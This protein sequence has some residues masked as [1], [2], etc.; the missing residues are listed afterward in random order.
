MIPVTHRRGQMLYV[1]GLGKTGLSAIAALAKGGAS[2]SGWDDGRTSRDAARLAGVTLTPPG[3][4]NWRQVD[5]LVL[6]PGVA[7]THPE[8]HEV[9]RLARA[10]DV[11]VIGDTELFVAEVRAT[12]KD[13]KI[14]AITGTNGKS[15]TTALVGHILQTAGRKVQIGGN[16]GSHAVLEL[17][18]YVNQTC[19]VIEFSSY[20]IDLTPSLKPDVAV[21][22]NLSPDHLDRHGGFS[23]Y[24]AVKA[25]IF[26]NQ[27]RGDNLVLGTDDAATAAMADRLPE[28][29]RVVPIAQDHAVPG[30]VYC[31]GSRLYDATSGTPE[32]VIDLEGFGALRGRHNR[33]NAAA[34]TAAALA[35][36][37]GRHDIASGLAGFGG[38]AHR[39]E[40]I[41]AAGR[42]LLVNDSKATNAASAER[43]LGS[44]RD[45]YW[46]AGGRAKAGGIEPLRP[47]FGRIAG[48][49]LIGEA[50]EEFAAT[51]GGAVPHQTCGT[52]EAAFARAAADAMASPAAEPV[53]LLAPACASFDQYAGFE[54]RGDEFRRLAQAL[55]KSET[56]RKGAS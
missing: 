53:V 29:V 10:H 23:G 39:M 35:L 1:F 3:E 13:A 33:Q 45:I 2:I 7:L 44:F 48:A 51:L 22:L 30:G 18:R 49:Y 56:N 12:M 26:A 31:L 34:A 46:I 15:T 17:K 41:G 40:E 4:V 28:G 24:A 50:A 47:L 5:A 32:L 6:S 14:V 20:Q 43:A 42:V 36:G 25:K 37:L 16:I 9:V 38:L 27:G 55:I 8:P 54:H 11:P 52:L 21:L 19:Y